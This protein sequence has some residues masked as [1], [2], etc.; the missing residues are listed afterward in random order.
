MKVDINNKF[1]LAA[2]LVCIYSIAVFCRLEWGERYRG[3]LFTSESALRLYYA[4]QVSD[5]KSLPTVDYKAQYPEGLDL[6]SR[7][8]VVMEYTTGYLYSILGLKI[9]FVDFIRLCIPL[10]ASI[11]IFAVYLTVKETTGSRPAGLL[12]ALFY[13]VALPA[14]T[15]ACGWEF[16]HETLALPALYFQ[17]YF[18]LKGIRSGRLSWGI[19]SGFCLALAL[20][21]WKISQLYFLIFSIFTGLTFLFG[22]GWS[23]FY[24]GYAITA[25][26]AGL[27]GLTVPFLKDGLFLTSFAM[28]IFYAF[29]IA[30]FMKRYEAILKLR[31]RFIFPACLL[32]LLVIL[33]QSSRNIHVYNLMLYKIILLGQK[34][35][36]PLLLPFDVRALWIDPFVGPSLF[37][38]IYFFCPL[39]LLGV[40]SL[41]VVLPKIIRGNQG[42]VVVPK[43]NVRD[44]PTGRDGSPSKN[45]FHRAR[46]PWKRFLTS[47]RG[48]GEVPLA[49]ILY[50]TVAFLMVYLLIRRLRVF[51]IY[52]LILLIGSLVAVILKRPRPGLIIGLS[53][54]LICLGLEA[55]KPFG[56][57][58][59]LVFQPV[60]SSS[61][62]HERQHNFQ[63]TTLGRSDQ[64]LIEWLRKN[65]EPDEVILAPYHISP[66]IRAYA[67][68]AVNLTSL[69]EEKQLREKVR[70]FTCSLFQSEEDLYRLA[71]TYGADYLV[72]SIDM[73]LDESQNSRHY[74]AGRPII[75]ED[76]AAYRLHFLPN[77]LLRFGLIYEN[78]FFRVFRVD[79]EGV[80]FNSHPLYFRYDLLKKFSGSFTGFREHMAKIYEVYLA[81]SRFLAAGRYGPA[82]RAYET[83]LLMAPGFPEP[84]AGLGAAY[85]NMGE[86]GNAR[87]CYKEYLQLSPRGS[88]NQEIKRRLKTISPYSGGKEDMMRS[89]EQF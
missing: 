13:A 71:N 42:I 68:R 75:D 65:T 67:D 25:V 56:L 73:I 83:S 32:L 22:L 9:P 51:F 88:F 16:L 11:S 35:S 30:L 29:L 50:N 28:I 26:F 44:V 7:N 64:D 2:L 84:Y 48:R 70:E 27:A 46:A 1:L 5:G 49:F 19:L 57:S 18:F 55:G 53:L 6:F 21:S 39:L 52:Y 20:A 66:V 3:E 33:P 15:R 72:Y 74:L 40:V 87:R 23:G 78:E 81:G 17:G 8:P 38:L 45:L 4:E 54:I 37:E 43:R 62:I 24:R 89:A 47:N 77:T 82:R 34:P 14:V 59:R 63:T 31:S 85:E 86:R 60:L 58:T 80:N 76:V 69:F 61:G 12:S 79:K 10:I 36:D 41:G